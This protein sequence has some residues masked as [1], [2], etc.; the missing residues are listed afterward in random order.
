MKLGL[1]T[2]CLSLLD[3]RINT[4]QSMIDQA[5][6][7]MLDDTKS[8]AGDKFETTRET[9][10]QEIDKYGKQRAELQKQ[11]AILKQIQPD[12]DLEKVQVGAVVLTDSINF[13]FSTSVGR[14]QHENHQFQVVSMQSPIARA[15]SS[16]KAKEEITFNG[17]K[18]A[19]KEIF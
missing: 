2:A 11:V 14:V 15:F 6:A 18:Y 4:A 5:E 3:E 13:F 1:I 12:E 10:Q 17:K 16:A 19:I 9:M 8:S 7:T